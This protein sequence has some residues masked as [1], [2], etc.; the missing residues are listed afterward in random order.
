MIKS[1]FITA[2]KRNKI[3]FS[4]LHK[5]TQCKN[6]DQFK[7][8]IVYQDINRNILNKIKKIDSKIEVI[9]TNYKKNISI[10]HKC[11]SNIYIGFKK[12][13]EDYRSEYV[14]FLED[15]MLPAY[16]FLEFHNNIILNYQN[17]EKFFAVNSFSKEYK[18]YNPNSDF[19]YSKFIFGL[20]K[21]WSVP[22]KR[23]KTFKQMWKELF[24]FKID[25]F[26]DCFFE[27]KI[28][29]KYYVIMPYRSR[30]F[31]QPSNGLNTRLSE[32]NS[33]FNLS[34]KKSF[35]KKKNYETKN[36]IFNSKMRYGWRND[37]LHYS[38]FNIFKTKYFYYTQKIKS[39]IK[40]ILFTNLKKYQAVD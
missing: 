30:A 14:I 39:L 37:C 7:K 15:D 35:L 11:N 32:R 28:K 40:K 20:G 8:L 2:Y 25:E 5:L 3:F 26:W 34:W 6:Y 19:E 18:K 23:W 38:K 1:I 29:M 12:C 36:Y 33:Q 13:F 4:T 31:E 9:K 22:K 21:G 16:D 24:Y 27:F 10:I 17:D